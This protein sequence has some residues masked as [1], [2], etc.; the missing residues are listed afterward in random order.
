MCQFEHEYEGSLCCR[1]KKCMPL[2]RSA[3]EL[4]METQ[5]L[6][7]QSSQFKNENIS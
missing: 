3:P 5:T 1:Q 2:L 6:S 7:S 4:S